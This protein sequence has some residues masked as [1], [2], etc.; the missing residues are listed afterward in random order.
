MNERFL[1]AFQFKEQLYLDEPMIPNYDKIT[2]KR[3]IKE[4]L[5]KFG[6]KL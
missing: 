2:A 5:I 1:K 6:Y 4:K 3:F